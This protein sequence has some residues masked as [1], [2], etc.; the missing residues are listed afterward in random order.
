[1]RPTAGRQPAGDSGRV[2]LGDADHGP[3]GD[4]HPAPDRHADPIADT[5]GYPN[6][7]A[8]PDARA[9]ALFHP[10]PS[11][12]DRSDSCPNRSTDPVSNVAARP[13]DAIALCALSQFGRA[14]QA[15]PPSDG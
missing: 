9:T 14:T 4:D 6:P 12:N 8:N 2:A 11:A 15:A 3:A 13:R 7:L 10:K 5:F 1:M